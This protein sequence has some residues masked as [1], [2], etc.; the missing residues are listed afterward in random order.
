M[1]KVLCIAFYF[2]PLAGGGVRRPLKFVRYLPEHGW[3]PVVLTINPD[4]IKSYIRDESLLSEIPEAVKICRAYYPDYT[5]FPLFR[6]SAARLFFEPFR[7]RYLVPSNEVSWNKHAYREASKTIAKEKVEAIITTSPPN[8][9]NLLG[10]KL[11]REHNIPWVA[12]IRDEWTTDPYL[13]HNFE[14][15]PQKRQDRE[16]EMEAECFLRANKLIA[17]S[18]LMKKSLSENVGLNFD[19]IEIISNGYDENDFQNYNSESLPSGDKFK[20]LL[21][22]NLSLQKVTGNL[23]ACIE[24]LIENGK[25]NKEKIEIT[26]LTQSDHKHINR[27]FK[28]PTNN[29]FNFKGYENHAEAIKSM[30]KHHAFMLLITDGAKSVISG[31][32]FEYMRGNRPIMG[33]LPED[34]E[35]ARIIETTGTGRFCSS[36]DKEKMKKL[37]IQFHSE[38]ENGYIKYKPNYEEIKKYDRRLLTSKL[39]GVLN[40]L[41]D[42]G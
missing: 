1:R 39:A 19:N 36:G 38:W 8:S 21:M 12:D 33:F 41:V 13:R 35:A 10:L 23:V 15:L 3:L 42:N 31:R 28:N 14:K 26:V 18:P 24:E 27:Y 30:A 7:N 6:G 34:G 4:N 9:V 22:G 11:C 17:I 40:G 29:I 25:I 32:I 20:I 16:R 2:P 5:K 37:I